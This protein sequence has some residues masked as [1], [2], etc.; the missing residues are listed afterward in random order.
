MQTILDF[1]IRLVVAVQG[2][3]TWLTS[4]MKILSF[5]GTEDFLILLLPILY[6]CVDNILGIRVAIILMLST[7][8]NGALK[9]AFHGPRPYW[10]SP[11]VHGMAEE[12]SFGI[13]SNHAQNAVAVWGTLAARLKKVWGWIVAVLLIL[14]I[15]FSRLFLGVHFPHDVLIGWLV[16]GLVLWLALRFWD[17][18]VAWVKKQSASWQILAAFLVSLAL[19]LLSLIPA[20]W[21][22][23]T[24]WQPPQNWAAYATQAISLQNAA[25]SAGIVFGLLA[26]LVW[27]ARQGGFQTRGSWWKLVLRYLL[28][29]AGVLVIRYGLKF[30]FPEGETVLALFLR[31]LRYTLIGFW[32]SAMAPWTFIRLKLA[33]KCHE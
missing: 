33:D 20:I 4:P 18:L 22:K 26:G 23:A 21:L 28:G 7:S 9:L 31:Y 16:G 19:F 5:L 25:T 15:G 29:L 30:I 14:L 24:N 10:Y 32:V 13:P 3:G 12:T 8:L 6:W 2:W 1:G 27:I 17:P 11:S